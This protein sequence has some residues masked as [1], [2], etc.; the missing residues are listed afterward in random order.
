MDG[1]SSPNETPLI[2]LG[3]PGTAGAIA[4]VEISAGGLLTP[5]GVILSIAM[6]SSCCCCDCLLLD[7]FL[8][9]LLELPLLIP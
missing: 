7:D 8:S 3:D 4:V 5:F 6:R 2:N 1:P 9:L